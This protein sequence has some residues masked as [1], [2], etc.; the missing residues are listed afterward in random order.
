M[1]TT[2]YTNNINNSHY[3]IQTY[4][5][6]ELMHVYCT[7]Y[8]YMCGQIA[9]HALCSHRGDGEGG[10]GRSERERGL[11]HEKYEHYKL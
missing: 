5:Q 3:A 9:R 4:I 6:H 8:T 11:D 1:C 7:L 2:T 10:V